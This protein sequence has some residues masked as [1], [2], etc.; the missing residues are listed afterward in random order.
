[1]TYFQYQAYVE[2]AGK[3][4]SITEFLADIG[5][6]EDVPYSGENWARVCEIIYAVAH[7]QISLIIGAFTARS[8]AAKYGIPERTAQGWQNKERNAPDYVIELLG[9]AV[10]GD[11]PTQG[12]NDD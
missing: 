9:F 4:D 6:G 1:M 7:N 10:I 11:I 5:F 3:H 2:E 8:F 12:N